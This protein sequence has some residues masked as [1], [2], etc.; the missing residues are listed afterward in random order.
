MSHKPMVRSE[1]VI[2]PETLDRLHSARWSWSSLHPL[3]IG[4]AVVILVGPSAVPYPLWQR[5]LF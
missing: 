2:K 4:T 3:D 1:R 5:R